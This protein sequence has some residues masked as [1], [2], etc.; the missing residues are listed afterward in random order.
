M[1]RRQHDTQARGP[2]MALPI[3]FD[4]VPMNARLVD[5][6]PSTGQWQY[7][8]KWD[9]FRCLAFRDGTRVELRSKSGQ[10]LGRY[11]PELVAALQAL[12]APRFVLD[13]EIVIPVGEGLSFDQLLQRIHPAESRIRKLSVEYPCSF[14]IF[15]LLVDPNGKSFAQK[16][17][18]DRRKALEIFAR[19]HLKASHRI[20]LSPATT[21]VKQAKKWFAKVGGALDGIIAKR[22]ELPYQSDNR[23]G[24]V[25]VKRK[26]TADCVVGG[27]RY[28]KNSKVLGSLLLGLY[29]TEGL[30]HHVGFCSAIKADERKRLT[31]QVEKLVE[32][33]GFTGRAPGG[34][35]RWSTERSGEWEP[36]KPKLVVEVEYDHFTSGRF[37]HGTSLVRWR[38]DKAPRQCMMKQVELEQAAMPLRLAQCSPQ[39]FD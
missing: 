31:P 17:L 26:R 9:G 38:P 32:S 29:D 12:K 1:D 4:Y 27:F 10:P 24:M 20:A 21:D 13:G 30:L 2:I 11:F 15:D 19:K 8:P 6:I 14:I 36:L 39:D 3:P 7:E 34:P 5:E 18:A 22:T 35:S 25:K 33:P 28:A 37:R 23:D 16:P